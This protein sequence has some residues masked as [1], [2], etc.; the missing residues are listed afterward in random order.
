MTD[1]YAIAT[2]F[3]T[4]QPFKKSWAPKIDGRMPGPLASE[5][6]TRQ[7]SYDV[8]ASVL[9]SYEY[10]PLARWLRDGE[11][12][13]NGDNGPSRTTRAQQADLRQVLKKFPNIRTG[14]VPFTALGSA[15]L[16]NFNDIHLVDTTPDRTEEKRVPCVRKECHRSHVFE[17][18][19][20]CHLRQLH[21]L[22]ETLFRVEGNSYVS[23]L[24]RN[25]DPHRRNFFLAKLPKTKKKV[26]TVDEALAAL[27][28]AGLPETTLR[29]GEW[30]LVPASDKK[31][32]SDQVIKSVKEVAKEDT[33]DTAPGIPLI[34]ADADEQYETTKKAGYLSTFR[35][36]RHRVS[37]M[38]CDGGHVYVKGLMR[39]ASHGT[40]KLGDGKTWFRVVK[41]LSTGSWNA[42]GDT[43]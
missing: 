40:L 1:T 43:D 41:N 25:D 36:Q 7:M 10:W 28:P 2:G 15:A 35:T 38:V 6:G 18:S 3:L 21:F 37:R 17:N 39:D 23:G 34:S 27:R 26:K 8:E 11:L 20:R 19:R 16:W 29:Q 24:D 31:F 4:K 12:L 42:E 32:K 33:T 22:G 30:F 13:V 9:L 5:K 14:L